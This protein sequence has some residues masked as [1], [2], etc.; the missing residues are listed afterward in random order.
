L[1]NLFELL[2]IQFGFAARNGFPNFYICSQIQTLPTIDLTTLTINVVKQTRRTSTHLLKWTAV[3]FIIVL[4]SHI[5]LLESTYCWY[6][7]DDNDDD[8]NDEQVSNIP[9]FT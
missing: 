5:V 9:L 7:D 4:F 3:L 2:S 6:Y 1:V 8:S